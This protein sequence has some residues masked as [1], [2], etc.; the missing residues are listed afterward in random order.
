MKVRGRPDHNSSKVALARTVVSD[1]YKSMLHILSLFR[2]QLKTTLSGV[3]VVVHLEIE[4][5][6]G[7]R[8]RQI[9]RERKM[10]LLVKGHPSCPL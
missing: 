3:E 9:N 8:A 5:S 6:T 2:A 4:A 7:E 10:M 1:I